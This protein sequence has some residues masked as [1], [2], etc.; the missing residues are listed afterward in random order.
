M[1][2]IIRYTVSQKVNFAQN[3]SSFKY[4]FKIFVG[5]LIIQVNL[6]KFFFLDIAP[7]L[8]LCS[9]ER[10]VPIA[11]WHSFLIL[12]LGIRGVEKIG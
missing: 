11:E 1:E 8:N 2:Q 7:I 9:D 6:W 4:I 3:V 12:N 5:N 10:E